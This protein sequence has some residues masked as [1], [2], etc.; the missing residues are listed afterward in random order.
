MSAALGEWAQSAQN[1]LLPTVSCHIYG[2]SK[3]SQ[4]LLLEVASA[5]SSMGIVDSINY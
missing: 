2:E 3:N 1:F 5:Y 4:F